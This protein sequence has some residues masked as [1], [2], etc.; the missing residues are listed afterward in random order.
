MPEGIIEMKRVSKRYGAKEALK[1][2]DL[3]INKGD[4]FGL[5]GPNGAGKSTLLKLLGGLIHPTEGEIRLFGQSPF[6]HQGLFDRMGLLIE[7]AGLYPG[8]TGRENLRLLSLAYGLKQDDGRIDALL[9]QM[10]LEKDGNTKVKHYS[11]GMKQRLGIA[12][13]LLG[14]PDVLLLDEPING[15]D[16]QGIA[17]MRRLIAGL[18]ADGLTILISSHILEE[19][20]KVATRYAIIDRGEIVEAL[21]REELLRKC[22]ER[23]ELEVEEAS[24]AVPLL[25][26]ELHISQYKVVDRQT[27][28]IFDGHAE[29]RDIIAALTGAGIPVHS[30]VSRKQSLEQYFLER[31]GQG[32][33]GHA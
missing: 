33:D 11:M 12:M 29:N 19:L 7:Q 30:I 25:E 5:I 31:T 17:D 28:H 21:T 3:T 24:A 16:P 23:I 22:G 1:Q 15:L 4:I 26:N 18:K 6:S 13:A 8:Y 2:V 20:S 10:G 27:I 32:G 14:S 9:L